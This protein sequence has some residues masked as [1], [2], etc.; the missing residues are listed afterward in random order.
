[1]WLGWSLLEE[2]LCLGAA[3][4]ASQSG[5]SQDQLVASQA[6]HAPGLR[7]ESWALITFY[8]LLSL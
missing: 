5:G 3:V 4:L 6:A 1:M 8:F 7:A 2:E